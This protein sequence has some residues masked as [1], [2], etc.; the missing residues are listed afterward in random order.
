MTGLLASSEETSYQYPYDDG[1]Y[2][3][4]VTGSCRCFL[5]GS[6]AT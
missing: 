4:Q 6:P 2:H 1:A 3:L 5:A